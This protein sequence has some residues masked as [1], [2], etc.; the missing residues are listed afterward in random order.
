MPSVVLSCGTVLHQALFAGPEPANG[1]GTALIAFRLPQGNRVTRRF[2][3]S[4]TVQ[5]WPG[6]GVL[7]RN[8]FW[9]GGESRF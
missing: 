2:L 1:P 7:G 5:V 4:D 3:A 9:G 8:F 6:C